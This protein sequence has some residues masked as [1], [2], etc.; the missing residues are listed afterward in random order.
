M[1]AKKSENKRYKLKDEGRSHQSQVLFNQ[2]GDTLDQ[3]LS[4]NS[5]N[6]RH[7]VLN[8][9][10]SQY[11][12]PP[13]RKESVIKSYDEP[14]V[15]FSKSISGSVSV[16]FNFQSDHDVQGGSSMYSNSSRRQKYPPS[17]LRGAGASIMGNAK[18]HS[19]DK[20]TTVRIRGKYH[21]QNSI[22][23]GVIDKTLEEQEKHKSKQKEIK[24]ANERLK[25]LERLEKYRQDKVKIEIERLQ[26]ERQAQEET[27]EKERKQ[28]ILY[29]FIC[30]RII[31]FYLI[32]SGEGQ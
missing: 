15:I 11:P 23:E 26:Q 22:K 9:H 28:N 8:E 7:K 29:I 13:L 2:D 31:T 30:K 14:E 6:S 12:M 1:Q 4:R 19:L 5:Q 20:K 3:N 18:S 10:M 21:N 27:K 17:R 24:R 16:P 32:G 25:N